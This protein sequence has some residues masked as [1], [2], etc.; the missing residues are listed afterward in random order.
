VAAPAGSRPSAS[1]PD[2]LRTLAGQIGNRAMGRVLQRYTVAPMPMIH[3]QF[4]MWR[5]DARI[6]DLNCGWYSQLAAVDHFYQRDIRNQLTPAQRRQLE[7]AW[8]PHLSYAAGRRLLPYKNWLILGQVGFDPDVA[9]RSA[10]ANPLNLPT[11]GPVAARRQRWDNALQQYGPLIVG[12]P[13]G[14]PFGVAHFVTV[15]GIQNN[16]MLYLDALSFS[17]TGAGTMRSA[18]FDEMSAKVTSASHVRSHDVAQ[19]F[20]AHVAAAAPPAV[21]APG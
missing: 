13:F 5:S 4:L 10:I 1:Q 11:D 14:E 17:F 7:G 16:Q 15:V 9:A 8:A 19:L 12:G 21:A 6:L 3:R 20:A 18:D 2:R